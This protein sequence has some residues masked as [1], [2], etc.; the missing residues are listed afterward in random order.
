MTGMAGFSLLIA[1]ST[2]WLTGCSLSD[3][4]S[5]LG[6]EMEIA[7]AH[8]QSTTELPGPVQAGPQSNALVV[9]PRQQ[10]YLDALHAV[11]VRPS[12]DLTALSIGSYVCQAHA[13]KHSDQA[14]W[15]FVAPMVRNEVVDS[16][17]H[18]NGVSTMVP[19]TDE[20]HAVTADYIRIATE[21]LC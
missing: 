6:S 20:I 15:D 3:E 9:T 13:A 17:G 1:S 2:G 7:P 12:S 4:M 16:D 21:R 19:S 8:G 14:V 11:G 18:G 10:A 5:G